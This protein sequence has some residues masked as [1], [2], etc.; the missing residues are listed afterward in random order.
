MIHARMYSIYS[1]VPCYQAEEF[2][3]PGLP[4]L[5]AH[6][7]Q[8]LVV[9]MFMVVEFSRSPQELVQCLAEEPSL[10]QCCNVLVESGHQSKVL[11]LSSREPKWYIAPCRIELIEAHLQSNGVLPNLRGRHAII[12]KILWSALE[13]AVQRLP[14]R[15]RI[16]MTQIYSD[17][18][19]D[20]NDDNRSNQSSCTDK[21]R[22]TLDAIVE[23]AQIQAQIREHPLP[24]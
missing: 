24:P 10:R 19:L 22:D 5:S 17:I 3:Q 20:M 16:K 21:T 13:T 14:R 12:E 6:C 9:A 4:C 18:T 1:T 11:H 23:Y 15:H 7:G 2:L 8:A